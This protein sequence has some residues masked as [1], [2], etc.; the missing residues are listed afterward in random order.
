MKRMPKRIRLRLRSCR[1]MGKA[2]RILFGELIQLHRSVFHFGWLSCFLVIHIYAQI[3]QMLVK[4][5]S[6]AEMVD[7]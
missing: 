1:T 5:C 2:S 6:S 4:N 3:S 7:S